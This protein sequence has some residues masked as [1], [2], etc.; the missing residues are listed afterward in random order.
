M[1]K[2]IPATHFERSDSVKCVSTLS[3]KHHLKFHFKFELFYGCILH[4]FLF[5]II[6]AM[7]H[8]FHTN[9]HITCRLSARWQ[10]ITIVNEICITQHPP[11]IVDCLTISPKKKSTVICEFIIF[12]PLF[13]NIFHLLLCTVFIAI[14]FAYIVDNVKFSTIE[15]NPN[16]EANFIRKWHVNDKRIHWRNFCKFIK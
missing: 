10:M 4:M 7:C 12:S 5:N 3:Q 13:C 9:N 6:K 1:P 16:A 11:H 14:F 15:G 8:I 2:C